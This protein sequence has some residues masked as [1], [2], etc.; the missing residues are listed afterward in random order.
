MLYAMVQRVAMLP[1]ANACNKVPAD[2]A[3]F[4]M[5]LVAYMLCNILQSLLYMKR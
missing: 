4:V 3:R 1:V 2:C 5:V